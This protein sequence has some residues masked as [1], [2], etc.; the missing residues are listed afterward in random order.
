MTPWLCA[1]FLAAMAV[2]VD[3]WRLHPALS[4]IFVVSIS[5]GTWVR[6]RELAAANDEE[7]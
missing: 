4:V 5:V 7:A 3:L 6:W 1:M 2:S